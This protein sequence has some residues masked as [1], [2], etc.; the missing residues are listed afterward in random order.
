M[1]VSNDSLHLIL[2]DEVRLRILTRFIC[3]CFLA[4][5]RQVHFLCE[6]PGNSCMQHY[7]YWIFMELMLAPVKWTSVRLLEPQIS[8]TIYI[9]MEEQIL[10]FFDYKS[11]LN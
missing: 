7:P 8:I 6:Q 4:T 11:S 3:L 9:Y 2:P 10:V 5:A 1:I